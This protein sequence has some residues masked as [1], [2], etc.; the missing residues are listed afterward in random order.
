MKLIIDQK[1]L[2]KGI[3]IVQKGVS[4]KTTLPILSGILLKAEDNVLTLTGTDL[5]IGIE[6]SIECNVIEEGSIVVT[7]RIFGD[8]IRKLSDLPVNLEVDEKGNIHISCGPSN[9]NILGQPSEEYPQLEKIED[10][11]SF[12]IPKDLLKNMIRQTVFATAQDETRPILTGALLEITDGKAT[13]VA[14]DGYRL[15]LKNISVDF[16]GD[17]KVV[18]PSKTLNEVNKILEDDD[19]DV[20]IICADNHI[21][22]KVGNTII[23]SRL[24]E[25]QF[26]NY[27][28]IIRNEYKSKVRVKTKYIQDSIERASLLAR[29]GKNNLIKLDIS[30]DKLIIT[31]N[32]EIGNVHEEIPIQLDGN[33]MEIAFNSKYILDGIKVI[34]S[35]EIVMDLV[36]SV[37]PCIIKPLEDENYTYLILPVRL[38]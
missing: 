14:L 12:Q 34:D 6:T 8:I 1:E 25:G 18:I 10:L 28:D 13:L 19:S 9:F 26:L 7:S 27:K 30:D 38:A 33:D 35:E 21:I 37:N 31:S 3:N 22:F 5:E 15:A 32:S 29:E 2:S 24:L 23:T 16:S 17:V 36:S 20:K 4:S 11:N